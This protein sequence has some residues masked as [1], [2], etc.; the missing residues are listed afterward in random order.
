MPSPHAPSIPARL[1]LSLAV[2]A[3]LGACA[4]KQAYERPAMDI[5]PAFKESSAAA[6]GLW[7]PAQPGGD[8][9]VP[10][11]WWSLYGDATLDALQQQAAAGNQ[12][13]AQSVAR[14]RAAQAAVASSSATAME[15][16]AVAALKTIVTCSECR[17][18]PFD[19]MAEKLLKP[20][21]VLCRPNG[22]SRM[23]D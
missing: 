16:S 19:R 6:Q 13:I 14:L 21:N 8:Q 9:A 22:S 23:A 17:Y 20:T 3:L 1:A 12:D 5:P 18:S 4:S 15:S 7:Q 2:L 11:A 10:V